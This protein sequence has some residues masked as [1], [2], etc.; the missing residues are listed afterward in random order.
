MQHPL[1]YG[2]LATVL[3]KT[4]IPLLSPGTERA[5]EMHVSTESGQ[6]VEASRG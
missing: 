4:I 1:V 3:S 2:P 6:A 5:A